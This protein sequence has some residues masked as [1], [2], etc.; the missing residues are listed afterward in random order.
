MAA[1]FS[2]LTN[3]VS[4]P[5]ILWSVDWKLHSM[6]YKTESNQNIISTI[7]C[8]LVE[9]PVCLLSL[10]SAKMDNPHTMMPSV[11]VR[12]EI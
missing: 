11:Q 8:R 6:T 3:N 4:P 10:E 12:V 2:V 1:K 5:N 9:W 7:L